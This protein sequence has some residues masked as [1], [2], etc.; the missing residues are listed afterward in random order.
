VD[1]AGTIVTGW[2]VWGL[3]PSTDVIPWPVRGTR[4]EAHAGVKAVQGTVTPILTDLS[5]LGDPRS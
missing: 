3:K 1:G 4:W 2:K 5:S